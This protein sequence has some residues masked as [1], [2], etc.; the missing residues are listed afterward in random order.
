MV[1]EEDGQKSIELNDWKFTTT[2]RPILN[3]PEMLSLTD[4]IV[5]PFPEM[6]FGFNQLEIN[7]PRGS[8]LRFNAI[9]ALEMVNHKESDLIKVAMAEAWTNH[10]VTKHKHIKDIIKSYDWTYTTEYI[11]K[12]DLSS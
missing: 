6:F 1:T 2:K 9:E 10:S 12:F 4:R 8:I 3:Q 5:I 7:T 11:G